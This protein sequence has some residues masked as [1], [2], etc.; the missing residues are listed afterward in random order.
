M[1]VAK[2]PTKK[3]KNKLYSEIRISG[4]GGQGII[5]TGQML[6]E[7][8]AIGDGLNVAQSQSYGPE[9]RGGATRCDI[10]VSDGEI[11]FPECHELDILLAFTTE[12]YEKYAQN[13][14][15]S[16]TIYADESASQLTLGSATTVR[17]PFMKTAREKFGREIVANIIALGYLSTCARVVTQAGLKEIVENRYTGSKHLDL[18][19]KALEEGFRMG[20]ERVRAR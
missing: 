10:I 14:K 2:K 18:N 8:I 5:S 12:A 1:A 4:A 11:F 17:V 3:A 7:A 15:S 13:V 6:G 9:A 19:L 20:R 16:G